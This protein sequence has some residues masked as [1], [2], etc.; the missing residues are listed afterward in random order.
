MTT[1][2]QEQKIIHPLT[3]FIER[4][5]LF[6]AKEIEIGGFDTDPGNEAEAL[7]YTGTPKPVARADI[8]G[9]IFVTKQAN[10]VLYLRR[11]INNSFNRQWVTE[12]VYNFENWVEFE[13]FSDNG[14]P[15]RIGDEPDNERIWADNGLFYAVDDEPSGAQWGVWQIQIHIEYQKHYG[16]PTSR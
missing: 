15:P 5:P 8:H 1:E 10:F 6:T 12:L 14:E 3:E 9:N 7:S 16:Y 2:F 13:N 4:C 11:R